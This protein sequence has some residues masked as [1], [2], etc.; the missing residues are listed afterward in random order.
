MDANKILTELVDYYAYDTGC[1]DSGI[2]NDCRKQELLD[3]L[4]TLDDEDISKWYREYWLSDEAIS[5]GY[6]IED[7]VSF[8]NWSEQ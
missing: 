2:K 5:Q 6:G 1:T 8:Y 3:L 4:V 7:A